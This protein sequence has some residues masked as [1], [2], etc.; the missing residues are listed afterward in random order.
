MQDAERKIKKLED[1]I[2]RLE[3]RMERQVSWG[4]EMAKPYSLSGARQPDPS[5]VRSLLQAAKR[6][7]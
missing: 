3:A 6:K 7:S 5:K 4:E 2:K 1:D